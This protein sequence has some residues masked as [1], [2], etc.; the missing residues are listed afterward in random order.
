MIS[1]KI[2]SIFLHNTYILFIKLVTKHIKAKVRHIDIYRITNTFF[3]NQNIINNMVSDC[4][5]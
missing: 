5:L 1:K 4:H 2:K 3:L